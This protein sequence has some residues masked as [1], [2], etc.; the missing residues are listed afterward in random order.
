MCVEGL[1]CGCVVVTFVCKKFSDME[2]LG[3]KGGGGGVLWPVFSLVVESTLACFQFRRESVLW[4]VF[5]LGWRVYFSLF[6]V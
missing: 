5:S 6:P 1:L 4:P 2:G 3:E